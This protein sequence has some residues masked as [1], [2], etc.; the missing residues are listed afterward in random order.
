MKHKTLRRFGK[1]P[2]GFIM[3]LTLAFA[4]LLGLSSVL[5]IGPS[6]G[7]AL[8]SGQELRDKRLFFLADGGATLCRAELKNRLNTAL[9]AK[10][11]ALAGLPLTSLKAT[12][13]DAND[14]AQFL[15]DYVYDS[16][17]PFLGVKD[18][19]WVKNATTPTQVDL[20]YPI[21]YTPTGG[22]GQYQ[23]TIRVTSR[24]APVSTVSS[25]GS[26]FLF[27]YLYTI[28]GT[29]TEGSGSV[30]R[31]VTLEGAFSI[32]VQLDNFAR[33]ALFTNDQKMSSGALVYFASGFNYYGPVHTNGE[34]NFKGNPGSHFWDT[35][36]SV[37]TKVIY[38]NGASPAVP[39]EKQKGDAD[40]DHN[41]TI[42]VPIFD[43]ELN[44]GAT[45]IDLPVT[46]TGDAQRTIAL[47]GISAPPTNGVYLG[48][49]TGTMKMTGGIYV[50]GNASVN[51]SVQTGNI[52]QYSITQGSDTWTV[53]INNAS[54]TTSIQKN[55]DSAATY[56][57][58]PNGLLFVDGSVTGLAGT[59]QKDTQLTVAATNDVTI[60]GNLV[61]ENYTPATADSPVKAEGTTNLMGILSWT[62]NIHIG[63]SAPD[64]VN[65][66][67]TLMAPSTTSGY[68]QVL[69]DSYD[70][71]TLGNKGGVRGVRGT[72]TIL[73]G[74][75][76]NLYGPFGTVA[77]DPPAQKITGYAR[78]FVYD[79]RM[80][81]GMAPPYFPTTGNVISALTGL[82]DRPNWKQI[83]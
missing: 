83:P 72:A 4:V 49:D 58:L 70:S 46:T 71:T 32:R 36:E 45:K 14:P 3:F 33:Y 7:E 59:L 29:G 10:L 65:I 43:K 66:H 75:I 61:Y 80:A 76:E 17:Q 21:T 78:N 8:K 34:F 6:V 47:T 60:T 12:Y 42:D 24:V 9:P 48:N 23:C 28:T 64:D 18:N 68:G 79:K 13:V 30:S 63:T 77:G 31:T 1:Q 40:Y 82:T 44:L 26:T 56:T 37:S 50:K 16:A 11:A 19:D 62:K 52:A 20:K 27:R 35:I 53:Q 38:G 69:V 74:V 73:G 51:L 55:S 22:A 39:I 57:G 81:Q 2:A 15:V 25:V 41:G 67:A 5:V 54:K